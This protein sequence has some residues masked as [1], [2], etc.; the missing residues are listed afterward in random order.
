[1]NLDEMGNFINNINKKVNVNPFTTNKKVKVEL[2]EPDKNFINHESINDTVFSFEKVYKKLEELSRESIRTGNQ[3]DL[4]K[5][6]ILQ[7]YN[8]IPDKYKDKFIKTLLEP[9]EEDFIIKHKT[10]PYIRP[11]EISDCELKIFFDRCNYPK[12]KNI[13]IKY[14]YAQMMADIGSIL[15]LYI[16]ILYPFD[17]TEIDFYD[18]D[19]K[20]KGKVD[21]VIGN[22]IIE[23]K[24][25]SDLY[26]ESQDHIDQALIYSFILNK[27]DYNI[28]SFEIAKLHRNLKEYKV[29]HY[30]YN[31]PKIQ[32][33]L[34]FLLSK[35]KKVLDSI[36]M[37]DPLFLER[38]YNKCVFC[39][40]KEECKKLKNKE[41]KPTKN[42]QL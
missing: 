7:Y 6:I 13:E 5:K 15:H 17:K 31:N 22:T 29:L 35:I 36:E 38:D 9:K 16:Q 28:D 20:V 11:S 21:G 19:I 23:I 39:P 42:I 34:R 30:D 37:K 14:P 4:I 3:V 26:W 10:R 2:P 32:G 27:N 12:D 8:D 25:V 41:N 33:R 24:T 40:F 1:M 18:K